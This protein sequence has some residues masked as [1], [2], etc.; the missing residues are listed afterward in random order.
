MVTQI[1]CIDL[2]IYPIKIAS[3]L[4]DGNQNEKLLARLLGLCQ[5]IM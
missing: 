4:C 1:L 2:H 3:Y 5:N